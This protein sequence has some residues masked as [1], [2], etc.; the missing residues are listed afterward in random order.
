MRYARDTD[1]I[2]VEVIDLPEGTEPV[3]VFHPDVAGLFFPVGGDVEPFWTRDGDG[4]VAPPA[5][6]SPPPAVADYSAAIQSM[7]DA[8]ARERGYEGILSGASYAG[9]PNPVYAA[10]G[11]TLKAWRSA[12]WTYANA[13]LA[14]VQAGAS[15]APTVEAF[16]IEIDLACPFAWP[17]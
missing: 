2:I 12:V 13:E 5:Y 8:K 15:E 11:T 16:L 4:W 1:D 6:V 10:E 17:E 9:D 14:A 3:N 7:L